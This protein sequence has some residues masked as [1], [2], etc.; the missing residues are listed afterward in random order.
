MLS[1]YYSLADDSQTF[2]CQLT[3]I[4]RVKI[5]FTPLISAGEQTFNRTR[6]T[7]PTST[8]DSLRFDLCDDLT[9]LRD[10]PEDEQVR[11]QIFM[12]IAHNSFI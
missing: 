4:Q 10:I 9:Q 2:D 1:V 6:N 3:E 7:P 5:D 8:I 12:Y 11:C